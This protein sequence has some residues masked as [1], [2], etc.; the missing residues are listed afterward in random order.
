MT[1]HADRSFLMPTSIGD[2]VIIVAYI[3]AI[4]LLGAAIIYPHANFLTV[5]GFFVLYLGIAVGIRFLC[6]RWIG[7]KD[8][9]LDPIPE[10]FSIFGNLV[11]IILLSLWIA[12]KYHR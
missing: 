5:Y 7:S 2:R 3:V 9:L 12:A 1:L 8:G 6:H 4:A 10:A 11:V